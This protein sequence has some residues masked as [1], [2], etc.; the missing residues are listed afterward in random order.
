MRSGMC[1]SLFV[2]RLPGSYDHMLVPSLRSRTLISRTP[3]DAESPSQS[4]HESRHLLPNCISFVAICIVP[5][6]DIY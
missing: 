2:D 1:H 3:V 5:R 4:A 6:Y